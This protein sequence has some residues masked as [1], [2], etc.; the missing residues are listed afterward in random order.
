MFIYWKKFEFKIISYINIP[1]LSG[2]SICL[3]G[4]KAKSSKTGGEL[5]TFTNT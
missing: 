4:R 5:H 1:K 2:S 3:E